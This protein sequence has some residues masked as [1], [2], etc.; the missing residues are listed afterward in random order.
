MCPPRA[1]GL[2]PATPLD[3]GGVWGADDPAE[4]LPPLAGIN[5]EAGLARIGGNVKSYRKLLKKFV[6]NQ[7]DAPQAVA[8]AL[9]AGEGASGGP[10]DP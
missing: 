2:P 7:G 10:P 5:T 6:G 3:G 4:A 9:A 8:Q 1:R